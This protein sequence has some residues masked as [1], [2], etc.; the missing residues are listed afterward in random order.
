MLIGM[1]P[2]HEER[3]TQLKQRIGEGHFLEP[4]DE[5]TLILGATTAKNLKLKIGDP[6]VMVGYDRFG[7]L[8]AEEFTLVGIITSGEMGLD[9]GMALT[10]LPSLQEML[11]MS[12]RITG[13]VLRV[14]ETGIS[15][16]TDSLSFKLTDENLEIM[17]WSEMFPVVQEWVTLHNGFFY[18]FIGI[19]LLIVIAGELNTMLLSMLER[20]REFGVFMAIG[21]SRLQIGLMLMLEALLIGGLGA[22]LGILIGVVLVLTTHHTGIDLS[23]L[24]G[25]TNRFYVDPVIYPQLNLE[26]LSITVISILIASLLAGIYPAWRAVKLQPVEAIRFG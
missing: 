6:V 8:V 22:L 12:K 5:Y 14:P 3:V 7:A 4:D 15:T 2:D 16:L 1:E 21:T 18:L 20:T 9:R 23:M 10:N 26:H 19:V 25:S 13:I 24:L 11:D 17:P